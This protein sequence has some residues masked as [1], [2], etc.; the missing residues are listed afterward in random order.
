MKYDAT[1]LSLGKRN[2]SWEH[3]YRHVYIHIINSSMDKN[4]LLHQDSIYH[5]FKPRLLNFSYLEHNV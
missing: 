5:Q 3:L 2:F 1:T 4:K